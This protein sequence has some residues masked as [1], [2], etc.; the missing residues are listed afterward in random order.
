MKHVLSIV[1][2]VILVVALDQ[3]IK[4]LIMTNLSVYDSREIFPFLHIVHVRNTGAA[5]GMFKTLGSTFFIILS[6]FAIIFIIH[7]LAKRTYN[8]FGLALIL[9]GALGNLID[10]IF[11][12]KVV[13]FIDLS[14]G[15]YHWP[16]FN[17]ADSS[18][19]IG[20]AVILL[21]Y[22]FKK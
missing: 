11:Y 14:I 2:I 16:A 20:I 18:L 3:A 13:D 6:V 17:V 22:L 1:I 4:Y 7:L 21:T 10:R 5:F 9:G 12:G 19:T 15:S 8:A